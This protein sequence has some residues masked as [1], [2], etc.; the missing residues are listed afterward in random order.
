MNY[1][2]IPEL[3][4]VPVSPA[5]SRT[6]V[7]RTVHPL[8]V[9][10]YVLHNVFTYLFSVYYREVSLISSATYGSCIYIGGYL[11]MD[12]PNKD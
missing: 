5:R 3:N 10:I 7:F 8:M 11:F 6:A 4:R 12:I 1:R 9:L 2:F